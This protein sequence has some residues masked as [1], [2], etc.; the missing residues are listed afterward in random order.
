LNNLRNSVKKY[1]TAMGD[2]IRNLKALNNFANIF[3]QQ[4]LNLAP[5]SNQQK[6]KPPE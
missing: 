4:Q 6:V 3:S 5:L 1:Q 2:D